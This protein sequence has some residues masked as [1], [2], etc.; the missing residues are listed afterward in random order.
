MPALCKSAA[1]MKMDSMNTFGFEKLLYFITFETTMLKRALAASGFVVPAIL[2][3]F[4]SAAM[5]QQ[6]DTSALEGQEVTKIVVMGNEH[7]RDSVILREM[8]TKVGSVFH[9]AAIEEDRKRI[10]NLLL[11]TRVEIYPSQAG[12]D[13]VALIIVVSERWHFFPYPLF[14]RNE[15]SWDKWSYGAG[16]LHNNI[17]GLNNK[18][19]TELWFGYNPGGMFSYVNPWFGGDNHFYYKL[20]IY[21]MNMKSKTL[22]YLP[23]FDEIYRGFS[24]TF[25]KRWGYHTY[26]T[27][28]LGYDYILYPQEYQF[29]MPSGKVYQHAP[30]FGLAFRYDTRDLYE[31]PRSGWFV[32][33]YVKETTFPKQIDYLLFGADVRHYVKVYKNTALAL[34]GAVDLSRGK[35]PVYSRFYVGYKERVRGQ[36]YTQIEGENRAVG[37]LELRI[38]L[39]PVRYINLDYPGAILGHYAQNLPFGISLG[40]FVDA[41]ATWFQREFSSDRDY[42]GGFGGGL[43]FHVP[44]VDVFRLEY[45]FDRHLNGQIVMDIG[46]AF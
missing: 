36:F 32:D 15:R 31:Y 24:A 34:R 20:N 28:V 22:Q 29:L 18:L 39:L 46:A 10:Q 45:A 19:L 4:A 42:L 5:S 35:I 6:V 41:G 37:G 23:R 44:Y 33:V 38:P 13:K 8:K 40:L 16:V 14:F 17:R 2:L 27:A 25:G 12:A 21:S 1:K 30:S 11:F 7:T 43:H 9:V 26:A 3:F